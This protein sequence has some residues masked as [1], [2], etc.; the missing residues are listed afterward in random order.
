MQPAVDQVAQGH[1]APGIAVGVRAEAALDADRGRRPGRNA[2]PSELVRPAAN[3]QIAPALTP[4]E[5]HAPLPRPAQDVAQAV[6]RP[7]RHQVGAAAAAD[8]D[9]VLLQQVLG[10]PLG[11]GA[12][13][14]AC[15]VASQRAGGRTRGSGP[16]ASPSRRSP[17]AAGRSAGRCGGGEAEDVVLERSVA[18]LRRPPPAPAGDDVSAHPPAEYRRPRLCPGPAVAPRIS[19]PQRPSA[20]AGRTPMIVA[21]TR[22]R[23]PPA[24]DP[25]PARRP[26]QIVALGGGGFSEDPRRRRAR[27]LRPRRRGR[28]PAP[29]AASCPRRAATTRATSSSSTARFSERALRRRPTWRS[30]TARSTTSRPCCCRRT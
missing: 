19:V 13:E 27:R 9:H 24:P 12:E 2:G 11:V 18:G 21:M 15:G 5:H 1:Q 14:R 17:W 23:S 28:R 26:R 10:D 20:R 8:V 29:R 25:R 6:D 16:P 4:D 30:S 3:Q 7:D 22:A